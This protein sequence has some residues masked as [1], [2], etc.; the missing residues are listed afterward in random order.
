VALTGSIVIHFVD[1]EPM[2][3]EL[4]EI[5]IADAGHDALGFESGNQY[6]T[7]LTSP[8]FKQPIVLISDVS[9]P[10]IN[11]YDLVLEVRKH[12]P[13]QKIMLI[14]GNVDAKNHPEAV[15]HLCYTLEK[16]FSYRQFMDLL[17]TLVCCE[18][19]DCAEIKE[20]LQSCAQG[21]EHDCPLKGSDA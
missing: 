17:N 8:D 15:A 3:R 13:K 12:H 20:K 10:G 4:M 18:I 11:G 16:P 6:L 21:L 7:Y 14:T 19:G 9:M 5:F 2:I 1:D